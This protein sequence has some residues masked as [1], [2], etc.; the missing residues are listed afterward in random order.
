MFY[1]SSKARTL[2][3]LTFALVAFAS[4]CGHQTGKSSASNASTPTIAADVAMALPPGLTKDCTDYIAKMPKELE[5]DF[6][7]VPE[8]W[9]HPDTSRPI[10]I[11]YYAPNLHELA[12]MG[13]KPIAYFNGGPAS[14][15]HGIYE[16]F[17]DFKPAQGIPFLYLDQRGT[18]CSGQYP[19]VP[20]TLPGAEK[21]GLYGTRNIVRDAEAIRK[22]LF[23][24]NRKWSI[25]GQSFGS[26]IV[27]RYIATFPG[28]I[29]KAFAHG[30]SLMDDG[31]EWVVDRALS[32]KRV[33]SIYLQKFPGDD[34]ILAR[35]RLLLPKNYCNGSKTVVQCGPGLLD[36]FAF[37]SLGFSRAWAGLHSQI[38]Q[39]LNPDGSLNYA[40]LKKNIPPTVSESETLTDF[41]V[42][43]IPGR[44]APGGLSNTWSCKVAVP[45]LISRGEKPLDWMYS[46]CR[47]E[48]AGRAEYDPFLLRIV[49]EDYIRLGAVVRALRAY[50]ALE[51]HLYSAELDT[52][53]PREGYAQEIRAL[54]G[55]IYYTNFPTT[56]HDW[57]N[58]PSIFADMQKVNHPSN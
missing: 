11:F 13:I 20:V 32:Q 58:E 44:E 41:V 31:I 49:G 6:I 52:F 47:M 7:K 18:G 48:L 10:Y 37:N 2:G 39:I 56:G 24:D 35:A 54:D 42:A 40:F 25:F 1:P 17:K 34:E 5:I 15:S 27:H 46:E 30:A 57:I 55:R 22:H 4:G 28:S 21:I 8:D 26:L 23:P 29:D 33:S 45:R 12:Q 19:N 50:P 16:F 53:G 38:I 3:S 14:P 51:F 36:A 43:V 9:D